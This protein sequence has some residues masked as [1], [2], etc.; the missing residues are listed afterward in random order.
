MI[1]FV[2][3]RSNGRDGPLKVKTCVSAQLLS[4]PFLSLTSSTSPPPPPSLHVPLFL[5]ETACSTLHLLYLSI[6]LYLSA[7]VFKCSSL[8]RKKER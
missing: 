6:Q 3:L 4:P 2:S 7:E 8:T 1:V 5:Q